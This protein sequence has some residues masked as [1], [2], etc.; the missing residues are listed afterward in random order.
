MKFSLS[1]ESFLT[2]LCFVKL[3]KQ[4]SLAFVRF[5]IIWILFSTA[6]IGFF[7]PL[8]SSGKFC[9]PETYFGALY[10]II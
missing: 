7:L 8:N 6:T 10:S 3:G 5:N 4:L 2:V 9:P 1:C